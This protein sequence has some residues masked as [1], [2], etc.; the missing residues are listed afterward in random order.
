M[1]L[2]ESVT[3]GIIALGVGI[4][5]GLLAGK[6]A[7][8]KRDMAA[9]ESIKEA[10][11]EAMVLHLG[12]KNGEIKNSISRIEAFITVACPSTHK[13]VDRRLDDL[14]KK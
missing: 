12:T 4:G 11:A 7:K 9:E 13:L 1:V 5:T 8:R 3:I 14:E 6:P 2:P 10:V